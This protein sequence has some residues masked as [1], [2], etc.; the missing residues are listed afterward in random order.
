[1]K[2]KNQ[3]LS[4]ALTLA[5]A[6]ILLPTT[7]LADVGD[8][9][10]Y[11]HEGVTLNYI[12]TSENPHEVAV[13][14]HTDVDLLADA[15]EATTIAVPDKVTDDNDIS[16]T[17]TAL[18]PDDD[19]HGA[20]D[21]FTSLETIILP[22][23]L[24]V[25]GWNAFGG[26]T[27]LINISIPASVTSIEAS[28]FFDCSALTSITIPDNVTFIAQSVFV[29]CTSLTSVTLP[30]TLTDIYGYSF[31]GCTA[32]ES[33]TIPYSV[34]NI[35]ERAFSNCTALKSI[36]LPYGLT[37]M[38]SSVFEH[39]TALESISLP[40]NLTTIP[41]ELFNGCT[42]L[43]SISLP[44]NLT[45]IVAYALH[46]LD[47]LES[48]NIPDSV[49]SIGNFAFNSCDSLS[50]IY[51]DGPAPN[52]G[53]SVFHS[54]DITPTVSYNPKYNES[55]DEIAFD[56]VI[57]EAASYPSASPSYAT[58]INQIATFTNIKPE[59][60][61]A[62]PAFYNGYKLLWLVA[63]GDA[64][65][66]DNNLI[67][68]SE[69]DIRLSVKQLT[70]LET[71]EGFYSSLTKTGEEIPSLITT[72][73]ANLSSGS[74]GGGFKAPKLLEG[75]DQTIVAGSPLTIK[76]NG[77]IEE[78]LYTRINGEIIPEKYLTLKSGSVIVTLKP[79]Y[80]STLPAGEHE[81]SVVSNTGATKT[82]FTIAN[83]SDDS[84]TTAME[85]L[86]PATEITTTTTPVAIKENPS[87]G[88]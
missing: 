69:G 27:D 29:D 18:E 80:T 78:Y 22:N 60:A 10:T 35:S 8:E 74:V 44:E 71:P 38:E 76:T 82:T 14:Y 28:A 63:S 31:Y 36:S 57:I 79:D 40:P 51:F 83:S 73:T 43:K 88:R 77:R 68:M 39:C 55:W 75:G 50:T 86:T 11:E 33:I 48:I 46:D 49:T 24:K 30:E 7:A 17:V 6:V 25:I 32:L 1:M 47:A 20:F 84:T 56:G 26:C 4:L 81:I 23:T 21:E 54:F 45:T 65:I 66:T 85:E 37:S 34:T 52:L 58:D 12:V 9:F 2:L 5:F 87:T 3:L 15:K 64:I 53:S 67:A 19:H 13:T 42:A 61:M 72:I 59:E 62:L 16:Y 41:Y 70:P